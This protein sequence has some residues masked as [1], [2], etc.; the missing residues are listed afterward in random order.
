MGPPRL[1]VDPNSQ[2]IQSSCIGKS[3][4]ALPFSHT[5]LLMPLSLAMEPITQLFQARPLVS[6]TRPVQ[7]KTLVNGE[8][9][10]HVSAQFK[11][12]EHVKT[13]RNLIKSEEEDLYGPECWYSGSCV[14]V[15]GDLIIWSGNDGSLKVA[16]LMGDDIGAFNKVPG[17]MARL[18]DKKLDFS[19]I[20]SLDIQNVGKDEI[21]VKT[22]HRW[23]SLALV[24][25]LTRGKR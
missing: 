2:I 9:L 4:H 5:S 25:Q 13:M 23:G 18:S 3:F 19:R 21:L 8:Q 20:L 10:Q 11:R 14:R 12:L 24:K 6:F 15:V 17:E 16:K 7:T 1:N 22:R